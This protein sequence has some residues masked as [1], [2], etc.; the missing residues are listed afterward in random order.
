MSDEMNDKYQKHYNQILSGTISDVMM[1]NVSY[2]AN[3]KL[4]NEII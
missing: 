2:Q 3:I 4:A 1:K